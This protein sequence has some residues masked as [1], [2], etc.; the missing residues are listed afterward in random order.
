[1]R[2]LFFYYYYFINVRVM[3]NSQNTNTDSAE[4]TDGP[5][6]SIRSIRIGSVNA[7]TESG[8]VRVVSAK[9]EGSASK[10]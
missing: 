8:T 2:G 7:S 10:F 5:C 9:S 6:V 3:S 4:A 1:M